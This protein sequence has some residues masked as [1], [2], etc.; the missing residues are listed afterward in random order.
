MKGKIIPQVTAEQ[1][2]IT[3]TNRPTWSSR[4]ETVKALLQQA[5]SQDVGLLL[6]GRAWKIWTLQAQPLPDL[7]Q[8]SSPP[9]WEER[10]AERKQLPKRIG[11]HIVLLWKKFR[12][13]LII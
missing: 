9:S 3:P 1:L 11:S 10:M 6:S 4:V 5:F 8:Q 2:N 13:E 12:E 7:K